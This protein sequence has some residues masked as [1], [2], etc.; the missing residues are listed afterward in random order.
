MATLAALER[1]GLETRPTA[2]AA[3]LPLTMIAVPHTFNIGTDVVFRQ[4]ARQLALLEVDKRGNSRPFT[5]G[6]V[7][8]L[9][10]RLANVL[11]AHGLSRGERVAILLSQRHETAVA[12]VAV[13]ISGL[14]AVPLF[15]LFGEEALEFRLHDCGARVVITDREGAAKLENIKERLPALREVFCVDGDTG[16]AIDFHTALTRA[17]DRFEP[18]QTLA[19]DPAL[20]IYTSGTTG[21]PKGALHAHRVLLGHLP[22]VEYPHDGF[23][24]PGDRFWTPADWAWIGGLLDVLL[25]AWHHGVPVVAHRAAKFDPEAALHFMT[26]WQVRNVFLPPTSLRL[27]RQSGARHAALQLRSLASGGESLGADVLEWGRSAFALTINEF[28]GQTECNLV[29]GNGKGLP[30]QRPG[31]TGTPIPGHA[32]RIVNGKGEEVPHGTPGNIAVRRPD[33]VMFLGYWNNPAAT[34]DKFI[35]EWLLTGDQGLQNEAGYIQFIGRDDDLITS[36]GYRIGPGEIESCLAH[37][38][39]VAM[40]AVVGVPDPIRTEI[41]KAVIVPAPGFEPTPQL[42]EEIRAFVKKRL[43]AHEYPRLIEFRS[44][45]PLTATGKVMRRLLRD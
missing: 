8:K 42:A 38:P 34:A 3:R 7:S 35:G 20:I 32:V 26:R 11:L 28:Y 44:Q 31:W 45:L 1:Y 6:E 12:H 23:P 17:S 33:A 22:G 21:N 25:P 39:A 18:I 9:A 16:G 13:Y 43:A 19:E 24:Q 40:A 10:S 36:A 15:T 4:D 41:I 5:F 27:L 37:H 30:A 2:P 14:I 29:V